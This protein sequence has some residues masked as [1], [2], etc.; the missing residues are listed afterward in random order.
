MRLSKFLRAGAVVAA[1]SLAL[2]ACGGDSGGESGSE[3]PVNKDAKFE[4]GTTMAKIADSGTI[5]IGTKFEQPLF[6][7]KGLDGKLKGFDVEVGKIIAASLGIPADKIE[8]KKTPSKI[9]EDVIKRGEV[10]MVIAT[11]TINDKRKKEVSFAGPYY[12]AGQTLMVRKDDT[13]ITGPESLKKTGARVCTAR[14]ST[15][16][17]NIKEYVGEEQLTLFDSYNKCADALRTNQV[18]AVTTDNVIL[19]GLVSESDGKFKLA[20]EPFSSEPY[21]IGIKKGDTA[22]CQF[23]NDSL[24]K[25]A[26]SGAYK[27]AWEATAGEFSNKTPALPK[28]APCS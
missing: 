15:S 4:P 24:Q 16:Y 14:G 28:P 3:P 26:D 2:A 27:K 22:F 18:D 17:N 8:W 21:G 10:D 13:K 20:G 6:G 7:I 11:Y 5:R 9:R 12:E 1:A 25:A 19:L 23:I